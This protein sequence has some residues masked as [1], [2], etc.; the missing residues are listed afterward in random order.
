MKKYTECL[1]VVLFFLLKIKVASENSSA[2]Y[3]YEKKQP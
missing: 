3:K 2:T 1:Y